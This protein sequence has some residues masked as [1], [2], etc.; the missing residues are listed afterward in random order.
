MTRCLHKFMMC[1]CYGINYKSVIK[2]LC[3]GNNMDLKLMV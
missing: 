2:A 1:L 3:G